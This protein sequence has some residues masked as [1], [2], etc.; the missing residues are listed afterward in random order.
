MKIGIMTFWWDEDNYGQILQCYA[1]QKYLQDA[2]HD[3]YLIRYDPRHDFRST[4]IYKKI[5]NIFNPKKLHRFILNK[6]RK[7]VDIREKRNNYRGFKGFINKYIKQSEIIYYSYDELVKYPPQADLYIVGS[8]QVWNNFGKPISKSVNRMNAYLLNFGGPSVKRISYA[9]S[10][11]KEKLSN[12]YINIFAPLLKNF[13]YISVRE[14]SGLEICKRCGI[15]NAEWVPDPTMLF[16]SDIYRNL[17]KSEEMIKKP[18]RPYCFLYIV[19]NSINFSIESIYKW[20]ESKN[21]D[22]EY[23]TANLRQDK[24][25]KTY[26]TIPEWIYLLE[27]AEYVIT[28]S[29]HAAAFSLIFNKEYLVIPKIGKN[30]NERL[31]SLFAMFNIEDRI[32]NDNISFTL[33]ENK[34]QWDKVNLVLEQ[35][36]MSFKLNEFIKKNQH[37]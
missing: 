19:G 11:G 2:G 9:A 27:N 12:D 26:S 31:Y 32:M 30:S 22:V 10:F 37:V 18:A 25:K 7:F 16:N 20:A 24:Y 33:F 21:I 17:Y 36:R 5:I 3:A 13:D 15:N 8:D 34:I 28:N 23:V 4:P 1:L 14:E 6:K 35:L 29:F